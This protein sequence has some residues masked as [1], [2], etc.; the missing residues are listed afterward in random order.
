MKFDRYNWRELLA[1]V[2]RYDEM[3]NNGTEIWLTEGRMVYDT[4]K[5]DTV[6]KELAGVF[7]VDLVRLKR[8]CHE[9]LGRARNLPL[10]LNRELWLM[11][12]VCR[13][14]LSRHDGSRGYLVYQ[15][16]AS[17]ATEE[18]Q[19]VV[20][21]HSHDQALVLPQQETSVRWIRM[22]TEMVGEKA[23]IYWQ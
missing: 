15:Q 16:V 5:L 14:A 18:G 1:L 10:V 4:R 2:P 8:N 3:G 7:A 19:A 9:E 22:L 11:P 13:R 20:R 17:F 23:A 6:L 12:V 21:F